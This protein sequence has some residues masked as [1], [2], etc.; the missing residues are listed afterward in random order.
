MKKALL[1]LGVLAVLSLD[2]ATVAQRLVVIHE[3]AIESP[4]ITWERGARLTNLEAIQ[5]NIESHVSRSGGGSAGA[6]GAGPG[7][8]Y[9][10]AKLSI[11][12]AR[13]TRTNPGLKGQ[14]I[15]F[16]LPDIHLREVGKPGAGVTAGQAANLVVG[17]PVAGIA[18]RVLTSIDSLRIPGRRP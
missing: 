10:I 8:R 3:I 9:A 2:P 1:A 4:E 6:P 11:R 7:R 17:A 15:T 12:N 14:G 18:Q 5:R 13:V 16:T